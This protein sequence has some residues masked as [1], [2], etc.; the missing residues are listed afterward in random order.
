MFGVPRPF[1]IGKTFS[2]IIVVIYVAI[3][4]FIRFMV[5]EQLNGLLLISLIVGFI[6]LL[7]LW[8]M[9]KIRIL[10]PG[11]IGASGRD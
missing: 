10:N 3:T 1:R 6:C 8:A 9:I 5:E 4:L 11:W 2:R 7:L